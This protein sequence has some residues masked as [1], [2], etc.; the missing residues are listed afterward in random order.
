[1]DE[2]SVE[3]LVVG[4]QAVVRVSVAAQPEEQALVQVRL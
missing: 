3:L 4:A 1:V 2:L